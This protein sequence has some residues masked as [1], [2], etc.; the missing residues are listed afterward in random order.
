M[1]IKVK[2][3]YYCPFKNEENIEL[4]EYTTDTEVRCN[5]QDGDLCDPWGDRYSKCPLICNKTI[6]IT[7]DGK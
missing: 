3:K 6:T 7:W 2:E 4:S 5:L 1:E